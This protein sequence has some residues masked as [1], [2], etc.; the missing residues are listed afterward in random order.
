M[1]T[2]LHSITEEFADEDQKFVHRKASVLAEEEVA[3]RAPWQ[4]STRH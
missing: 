3:I 1:S 4:L 2:T